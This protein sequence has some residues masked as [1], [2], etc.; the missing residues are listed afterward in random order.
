MN[1][2]KKLRRQQQQRKA[3]RSFKKGINNG[4]MF[5]ILPVFFGLSVLL[6]IQ[7]AGL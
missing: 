7:G 4:A 6:F 5:L 3:L 2:Y 1:D